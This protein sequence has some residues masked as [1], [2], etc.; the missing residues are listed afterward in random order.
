LIHGKYGEFTVLVDDE[1]VAESGALAA[2]GVL[3]TRRQ[4][5]D[6]VRRRLAPR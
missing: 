6:A 4:V 2:I 5:L 1:V 3:P